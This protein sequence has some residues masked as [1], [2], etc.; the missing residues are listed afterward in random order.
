MRKAVFFTVL[1]ALVLATPWTRMSAAPAGRSIGIN[2]VLNTS[3]TRLLK[4]ECCIRVT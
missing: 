3:I 2:V 1:V 4:G